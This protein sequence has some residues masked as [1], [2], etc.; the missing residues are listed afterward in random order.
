VKENNSLT[1]M[2]EADKKELKRATGDRREELLNWIKFT[3]ELI[4]EGERIKKKYYRWRR[5]KRR[6]NWRRKK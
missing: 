2:L 1:A 6:Y 5:Y 3:E 4:R